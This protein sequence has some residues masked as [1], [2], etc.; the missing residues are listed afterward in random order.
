MGSMKITRVNLKYIFFRFSERF[1]HILCENSGVMQDMDVLGR[2]RCSDHLVVTS[3]M[4]LDLRRNHNKLV[5]KKAIN[6]LTVRREIEEFEIVLQ[7]K[8]SAFTEEPELRHREPATTP[9]ALS[10]SVH[11]K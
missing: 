11:Y 2:V 4:R 6:E 10:Q 8:Y 7:N 9:H 1:F 5:L 3:R